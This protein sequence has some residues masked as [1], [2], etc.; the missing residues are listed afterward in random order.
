[1]GE[2]AAVRQAL[3]LMHV[4]SRVRMTRTDPLPTGVEILLRIAAGDAEALTKA[5]ELT[6]R[7]KQEIEGA[8]GFYIEQILLSSEADSYRVLGA[9][10]HASPGELRRNMA[11]LMQWLHPDKNVEG[12]RSIFASRITRAWENLKT[13]ERRT[14]YDL[15]K[16][17]AAASGERRS[18][19]SQRRRSPVRPDVVAGGALREGRDQRDGLLRRMLR[20]LLLRRR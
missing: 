19:G 12:D 5:A 20:A 17:S 14:A 7:D 18:K 2:A 15:S 10:E 4:P 8:A 6:G 11:L 16:G 9:S 13:Q 1:M 3:D